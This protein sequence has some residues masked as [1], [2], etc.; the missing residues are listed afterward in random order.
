MKH[1]ILILFTAA[2]VLSGI[3][4]CEDFLDRKPYSLVPEMYF[5]DESELRTFAAGVYSVMQHEQFYGGDYLVNVAGGDD[6]SFYSRANASNTMVSA[7]ASSGSPT[8]ASLWR[9]LYE[10]VNRANMLLENADRNPSVAAAARS[11]AKAEAMFLRAFYYF[12]LVQGWG[13]VPFRLHSTETVVGLDAGRTDKEIIYEQIVADMAGAIPWLPESTEMPYTELLTRSAARGILA[14]VWLFRAGECFRDSRAPDE[15]HRQACFAAAKKWAM[16]VMDGGLHDLAPSYSGVFIDLCADRYNS[17]GILESIWEVAESGNRTASY[18]AAG[19]LGNT[20]GF[21][22]STDHSSAPE[23]QGLTGLAN[24][25]YSYRFIH[26]SLK[27]YEMYESEGDTARGDWSIA[28]YDYTVAATG[29]RPVTGRQYYYGKLLPTDIA[30]AGFTYTELSQTASDNNKTRMAAKY[31][32]EYEQVIPKNK[33][34]TP[35]NCP[36]LRYSDVLLMIAEAEN[37]LNATPTTLAYDCINA[38]R[39]RAGI[40]DLSGLDKGGF[41]DAVKKERAMEL[42]FEGLRRWDLIRWG[43]FY[44]EMRDMESWVYRP[45]WNS[46]H[47]FAATYYRVSPA[48]N[49]FPIPDMEMALNKKITANNPGW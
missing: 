28:N 18:Q 17:A 15:P 30:P 27:L 9:A 32:R 46:A 12:H 38:V 26:A 4:G 22:C 47:A 7:N 16:E 37:E 33:N 11:R 29:N 10:G 42:C 20:M 31:R 8:I 6:L 19:R 14:R 21:G 45:G 34:Y 36:L 5:N 35:I 44:R 24:P 48:Y 49:Y 13:D 39:R 41:R 40:A 43:D 1:R 3:A 2:A 23:L 25:G